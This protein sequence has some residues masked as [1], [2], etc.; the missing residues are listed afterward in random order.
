MQAVRD[1]AARDREARF[2]LLVPAT[3][4]EH[5]GVWF[6]GKAE[7][8][9]RVTG[10]RAGKTWKAAG[11]PVVEVRVGDRNP[12]YAVGDAFTE[13]EFDEVVISTLPV[14]VSRWIKRDVVRQLE[15][16][17]DVPITHVP[18]ADTD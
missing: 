13:G 3:H 17:L 6:E 18:T 16:A 12:V 9:A 15:R 11:I 10:E 8:A 1:I 4:V 2:V 14:G 7:E 5:L